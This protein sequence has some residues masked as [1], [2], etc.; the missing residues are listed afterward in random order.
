MLHQRPQGSDFSIY[1]YGAFLASFNAM[2][3]NDGDLTVTASVKI[4]GTSIDNDRFADSFII[5]T[6]SYSILFTGNGK[7]LTDGL[8][9]D[10]GAP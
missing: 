7:T 1:T 2:T 4:G 3:V 10:A 8:T 9:L 6:G 5:R